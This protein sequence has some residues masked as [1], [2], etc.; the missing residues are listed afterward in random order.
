[1]L[2]LWGEHRYGNRLMYH[3]GGSL[4]F[5]IPVFLVVETSSHSVIQKLG[6]I[7]LVDALTGERVELGANV[8]E[9]YYK[10]FG[11][12]NQTTV[13]EGEVGFDGAEFHPL[14]IDSGEFAQLLLQMRNN[15]NESHNLFVDI[16]VAAGNFSVMWHGSE[17][18]PSIYAT[19]TTF[20]LDIGSLGAGDVYGTTPLMTAILPTGV[21]SVQYM[22]VLTLRTEAG[23]VD[24]IS[25]ILTVT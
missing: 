4:L 15:D 5:V 1:Q 21:V 8:V 3:L 10:M 11:L 18:I 16:S 17:V 20:T 7:G 24:Q 14:S 19:N 6:G 25:L 9:A 22:V 2:A 23:V 13:T 12:L